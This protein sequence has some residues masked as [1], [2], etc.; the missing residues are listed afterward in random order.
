MTFNV[1]SDII[2]IDTYNLVRVIVNVIERQEL[3]QYL[4]MVYGK[5]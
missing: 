4:I 5:Y 3:W 2:S 1:Q